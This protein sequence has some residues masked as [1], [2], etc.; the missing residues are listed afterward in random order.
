MR[1]RDFTKLA[2]AGTAGT[3]GAVA[4]PAVATAEAAPPKLIGFLGAAT[5]PAW[6]EYVLSFETALRRKGWFNGVNVNIDYQWASGEKGTY[7][8]Y[9]KY[10]AGNVADVI[11][12]AG[13]EALQEA[14]QTGRKIPVVFAAAGDATNLPHKRITGTLNGQVRFAG[15]RFGE[16]SARGLTFTDV[17]IL[18]KKNA[19]N[20]EKERD[21]VVKAASA[22]KIVQLAITGEK[23]SDIKAQ[24]D[25]IPA[26]ATKK[27]LY[28]CTDPFVTAN[29]TL[30][31]SVAL[32]KGIP[33][34]YVFSQHVITGGLMSYGP[35]FRS[36]FQIAAE[37]VSE[38]LANPLTANYTIDEIDKADNA[39]VINKTTVTE[40]GLMN[41]ITDGATMID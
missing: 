41:F 21:E 37:R 17:Y 1:R 27:V 6:S 23:A 24:L 3:V 39:V 31:N 34:I 12:T 11:V 13:S 8:K 25:T 22:F 28:V 40:L 20:A 18:F 36:L 16:L 32:V 19:P 26:D 10:F 5:P 4:A 29:S 33:T 30:I 14:A 2:L 9:V 7:K 38:I 35:D 15:D